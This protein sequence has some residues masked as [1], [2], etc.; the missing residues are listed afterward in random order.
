MGAGNNFGSLLGL[1]PSNTAGSGMTN[2]T[3]VTTGNST[4][5]QNGTTA[6]SGTQNT[7]NAGSS[8]QNTSGSSTGNQV[9]TSVGTTGQS[10]SGTTTT[11][12][13]TSNIYDP[14]AKAALDA[15]LGNPQYTKTAAITDAQGAMDAAVQA[16]LKAGMP[17]I[18]SAAKSSGGY[19]STTQ[20]MLN[21]DLTARS[22]QAGANVV[23][24]NIAQYNALNAQNVQAATGAVDAT[25]STS[26]TGTQTTAGN[27]TGTT[28]NTGT[29]TSTGTNTSSTAG[30]SAS[31]SDVLSNSL[32]ANSATGTNTSDSTAVTSG[33]NSNQTG[34]KGGIG[35][36]INP[37]QGA[38]TVICTQLYNDGYLSQRVYNADNKYVRMHFCAATVNG[39]RAWA[40]PFVLMMRR[41]KTIYAIG[42]YFGVKWSEHCAAHFIHDVPKNRVGAIT[43]WVMVPLCYVLGS[44]LPDV[45]YMKL[46]KSN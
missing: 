24:Q 25:K 6:Q 41:S 3:Q 27:V 28:S 21:N 15:A 30:T 1:L 39:Y 9:N 38:G 20:D 12:S 5:T 33:V 22:A 44:I 23:L 10:S 32:T 46:Y 4:S 31:T 17:S 34:S 45:E 2:G 19:N 18:S 35:N 11:G 29:A 7:V 43:M 36:L 8:T 14:A 16:S 26:T 40:V 42:R 13:T 37:A